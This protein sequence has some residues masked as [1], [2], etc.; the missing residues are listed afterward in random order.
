M[1]DGAAVTSDGV[2]DSTASASTPCVNRAY[3]ASASIRPSLNVQPDATASR[4]M[5][6]AMVVLP[7]QVQPAWSATHH[8]SSGAL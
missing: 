1:E 4:Y 3:N 7:K 5:A 8:D 2:S 6:K